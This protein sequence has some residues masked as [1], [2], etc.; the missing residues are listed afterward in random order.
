VK[1]NIWRKLKDEN[2][3]L[4]VTNNEN[5]I[6]TCNNITEPL[7]VNGTG[8]LSLEYYCRANAINDETKLAP[9]QKNIIKNIYKF[10]PTIESRRQ[11]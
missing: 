8:I 4:Y 5:V 7:M 6:T 11:F 9:E 1:Y 10:R 3:W 2:A